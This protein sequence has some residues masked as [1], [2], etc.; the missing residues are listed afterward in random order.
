ME[1]SQ[2]TK[3]LFAQLGN[4]AGSSGVGAL[5]ENHDAWGHNHAVEEALEKAVLQQIGHAQR[6]GTVNLRIQRQR[7]RLLPLVT[8]PPNRYASVG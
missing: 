8:Y 1:I 5:I 7:E 2:D 6:D 4:V 3:D